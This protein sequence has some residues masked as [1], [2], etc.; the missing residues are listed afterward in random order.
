MQSSGTLHT[1]NFSAPA[2]DEVLFRHRGGGSKNTFKNSAP[3]RPI[4]AYITHT[5]ITSKHFINSL[6]YI[7]KII[8]PASE[9]Y[10]EVLIT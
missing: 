1:T 8:S 9:P 3:N 7:Q 6:N 4:V 10:L 2:K 5:A